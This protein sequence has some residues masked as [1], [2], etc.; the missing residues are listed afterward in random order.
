MAG[1]LRERIDL[2]PTSH[3]KRRTPNKKEG[4]VRT[5][6]GS[7]LAEAVGLK[8]CAPEPA[9]AVKGRDRVGSPTTQARR[10]RYPLGDR[11]GHAAG[12][13][14]PAQRL[15]EP[16]HSPPDQV[17][18]SLGH[19]GRGTSHLAGSLNRTQRHRVVQRNR[20]QNRCQTVETI[21]APGADT[22]V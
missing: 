1:Q 17:V 7:N 21:R 8:F 10:D 20:L 12:V 14:T 22:Q 9:Q 19:V 16:V 15:P 13:A 2:I 11:N 5:H 18:L 6:L 4:T 3:P